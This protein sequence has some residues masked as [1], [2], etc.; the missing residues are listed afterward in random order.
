MSLIVVADA[1]IKPGSRQE[2]PFFRMLQRLGDSRH[3]VIFLGDIFE[4]WI[5]LPGYEQASQRAFLEWCRQQKASRTIGFIEGNHEFFVS[6]EH[7]DS[8]SW[9]TPD[10]SWRDTA[11]NLFVHGDQINRN[12][13]RYLMFRR[14]T[15]NVVTRTMLRF[16]PG[17]P[18]ICHRLGRMLQHTNRQHRLGL[19]EEQIRFF[20]DQHFADGVKAIYAGHFHS[21]Y[22]CKHTSARTLYLLPAWFESGQVARIDTNDLQKPVEFVNWEALPI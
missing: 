18:Q 17:G 6:A 11:G 20:A 19:P 21:T 15:K 3:D 9:S 7:G 14:L 8:F 10:S 2:Q 13:K 1:H 16:L 4:L 5:A 22:Q 12:D